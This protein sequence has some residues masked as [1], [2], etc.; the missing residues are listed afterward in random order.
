MRDCCCFQKVD[1]A[2][3]VTDDETYRLSKPVVLRKVPSPYLQN[4]LELLPPPSA[5]TAQQPHHDGSQA[6]AQ[7][8][9]STGSSGGGMSSARMGIGMGD[10][11]M[12][13]AGLCQPYSPAALLDSSL[14]AAACA[15]PDERSDTPGIDSSAGGPSTPTHSKRGVSF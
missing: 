15:E 2:V 5:S 3:K 13:I 14:L 4:A 1:P 12:G 11:A 6:G 10:C 8:M 7:W 9:S